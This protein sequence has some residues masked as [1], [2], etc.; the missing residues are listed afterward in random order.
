MLK[1]ERFASVI[2]VSITMSSPKRHGIRKR[3]R[4]STIG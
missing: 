4:V 2:V 3:A 1:L